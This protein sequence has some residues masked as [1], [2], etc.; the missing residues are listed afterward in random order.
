MKGN[1]EDG[2]TVTIPLLLRGNVFFFLLIAA[3]VIS[4]LPF[5]WPPSFFWTFTLSAFPFLLIWYCARLKRRQIE[6]M[7]EAESNCLA[8]F[9]SNA[10]VLW[11]NIKNNSS[12]AIGEQDV[13]GLVPE[14]L[15]KPA[16]HAKSL[17]EDISKGKIYLIDAARDFVVRPYRDDLGGLYSEA[18]AYAN[19]STKVGILGTFI[20]FILTLF[21]LS[22]FFGALVDA[23]ALGRVGDNAAGS[24]DIIRAALQNLAYAFVKSIY[25]LVFAIW[26]ASQLGGLR[27]RID[28]SYRLFDDAFGFG[29]ELVNRMTLA[30]Q[31]MHASLFE[32]RNA[33]QKLHQRLFDH[34]G[35]VAH[36]LDKHGH[37]IIEQTAVFTA[38][39]QGMVSVQQ[40]WEHAFQRMRDAGNSFDQSTTNAFDKIE[41]G[42]SAFTTTMADSLKLFETMRSQFA[43]TS[44]TALAAIKVSEENWAKRFDTFVAKAI[45]QEKKYGQWASIVDNAFSAVQRQIATLEDNL[46]QLY[47]T[48]ESG[49]SASRDLTIAINR[50]DKTLR[51]P[52]RRK[53]FFDLISRR[54][55]KNLLISTVALAAVAAAGIYVLNDPLALKSLFGA[56]TRR[57]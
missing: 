55:I 43:Q 38:A 42:F 40:Q 36:A 22:L 16:L 54:K 4:L 41:R 57:F 15:R 8:A 24:V 44:D 7:V 47:L 20:G 1:E 39:A 18:A 49:A 25:G 14:D 11:K 5:L 17:I 6:R 28:K 13:V 9:V 31:A 53:K 12:A 3:F 51:G 52:V 45:E 10:E 37:L 30:D 33:L 23:S 29:R 21:N 48:H 27:I 56:T 35:A 2:K 34:S 46:K 50:L 32:V 19:L 26:I